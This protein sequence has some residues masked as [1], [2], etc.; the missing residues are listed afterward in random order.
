MLVI[1]RPVREAQLL[2]RE[3]AGA[4]G[5]VEL[6]GVVELGHGVEEGL[7]GEVFAEPGVIGRCAAGRVRRRRERSAASAPGVR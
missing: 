3:D 1:V 4:A 7:L 6:G 5:R 2:L